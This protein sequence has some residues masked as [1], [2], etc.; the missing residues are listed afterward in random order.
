M[1]GFVLC[2]DGRLYHPVVVESVLS[3]WR[4]RK[5]YR[6]DQ[7]RLEKWRDKKRSERLGLPV[8][9]PVETHFTGI[10]EP[11]L[12]PLLKQVE[13]ERESSK[14]EPPTVDASASMPDARTMLFR[15]GLMTLKHMTGKPDAGCRTLIGRW[16]K[17]A[18]DDCGAV[19][20]EIAQAAEDRRAEPVAW[21][22]A[23]F[24]KTRPKS[25]AELFAEHLGMTT[26]DTPH[27]DMEGFAE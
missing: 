9:T 26:P 18:K 6:K 3:A 4:E 22:E 23:C 20:R 24:T 16:L 11:V 7:E 12:K 25:N 5:S 21:L 17:A 1:R 13:R 2:S 10:S 15:D 27:F 19:H 8:E 14:K